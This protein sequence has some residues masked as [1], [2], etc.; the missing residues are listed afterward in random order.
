MFLKLLVIAVL[1]LSAVAM[2][3][4]ITAFVSKQQSN[5]A[6]RMALGETNR[7]IKR[8]DLSAAIN[9]GGLGLRRR[10]VTKPCNAQ[11]WSTVIT[12]G[13]TASRSGIGYQSD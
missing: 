9:H 2:Y 7:S 5:D 8:S 13:H 11:D 3:G 10:R 1:L 6:I 12:N 4:V